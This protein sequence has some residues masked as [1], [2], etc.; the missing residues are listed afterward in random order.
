MFT[1]FKH[2]KIITKPMHFFW[3][4]EAKTRFLVKLWVKN[5]IC[6]ERWKQDLELVLIPS[7][8]KFEIV[9]L[10]HD[11]MKNR[12]LVPQLQKNAPFSFNFVSCIFL[13]PSNHSLSLSL[14][15]PNTTKFSLNFGLRLINRI[16]HGN[17]LQICEYRILYLNT[18]LN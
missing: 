17:G 8:I 12:V 1:R 5:T 7:K 18:I 14:S 16:R 9:F 6:L 13:C 2:C 4:H 3:S 11:F 15:P 10:T